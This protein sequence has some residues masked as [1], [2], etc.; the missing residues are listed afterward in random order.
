[1]TEHLKI[2]FVTAECAPF[3]KT[4]GLGDVA[5]SLPKFIRKLK[6]EIFVVTP[7]YSIIDR[8][9]Y[10]IETV[11]P[12]MDTLVNGETITCRVNK[13]S[14]PGGVP[15]FFIDYEPFFGRQNIYYD[16]YFND[17]PDN[18]RRFTYLSLS[19]LQ[20]CHELNFRPDIVHSNDWH[21]AVLPAFLRRFYI[22]DPFFQDCASVLT[23][24]NIAYQGRYNRYYYDITGLGEEDFTSDK[25]EC[26]HDV[27]FLKG[28]IHFADMVNT[29]SK[30]YAAETRT[31]L[32]GHG[33]DAYLNRKGDN[34]IGIVNGADYSHWDPETD[35]LIPANFSSFDLRGKSV[36]KSSLQ[37]TL[38]LTISDNIPIIG[39]ISRLVEQKGFYLL[40]ECIEGIINNMNVQFAIVGSGDV[41]LEEFFKDLSVRYPGR[42]GTH[43]GYNNE[44]AH[45]IE[46][47]SDFF[48]MP[49]LSEPC[50]L[51]QIYS[52]KYGTLPVVRATGGLNDTVENYDQETGNG[53]GFK[54]WEPSGRA[55]YHTVYW[56]LDT[57]YNRKPHFRK[58]VQTA[59]Q[60]DFSWDE[61][62]GDYINLYRKALENINIQ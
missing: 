48:I 6:H 2:L 9:K 42:V 19:A 28:G 3:A 11:L 4:G 16:N 38:G 46:A 32:G 59:M 35:E 52:M 44:L 37:S 61:S 27:N 50:G 7:M 23:I 39:I 33:L 24:H 18:P 12:K 26:Y 55:V 21:T 29:V 36:C 13:T 14:L 57:Y 41:Q 56:A 31:S 40:S 62:A 53:T 30:G 15:V 43:I 49:S 17:Y 5:G 58:L 8:V 1:M 20:L 60:Q 45:L 25:F 51:N 47:G 54:F 34:Y 10:N 22:D